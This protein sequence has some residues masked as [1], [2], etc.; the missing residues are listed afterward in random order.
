[1]SLSIL[2]IDDEPPIRFALARYF[3]AK[4]C[5]VD[6]AATSEE[7]ERLIAAGSYAAAI[8]DLRLED[9]AVGFDL[10]DA[11]REARPEMKLLML[12]AYGSSEIER[13][14]GRHGV[15]A[16]LNKPK[17]LADIAEVLERLVGGNGDGRCPG[18]DGP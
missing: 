14:A 5:R 4:G 2:I 6:A 16:F 17:P 1:M 13:Q 10:I 3:G 11:L 18:G 12:T 15:D 7:A 9:G 8:V